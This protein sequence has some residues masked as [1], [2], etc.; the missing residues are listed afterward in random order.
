MA[1]IVLGLGTSH[2]P[3]LSLAPELWLEY[4]R[5]DQN[6]PELAYPPHGWVM[7][8]QAGLEYVSP[9]IRARFQGDA[10]FAA[11][12]AAFQRALDELARTLQSTEPDITV[13]ITDDQDEWFYEHNMPRFAVYWGESVPLIPRQPAMSQRAPE[14]AQAIVRGY[15]DVALDVPVASAFGRY[16]VEYLSEHD[17]D[18]AHLNY[19]CQPYGGRIARRY[20]RENGEADA[21]RETPS[22]EQGLPHGFSFVVKRLYDNKPRPILPIFQ[23]TCYP[24]NQ[25]SPRRSFAFG[26]AIGEAIRS[27]PE[28]ARVA[29]VASGGLSHFIVDEELDRRLL[30][31]LEEKDKQTLTSLPRERLYSATSE[32]LNWVAVGGAMQAT[33]LQF[34]LVDYVPVYRSPAGTGGG[35]AFGRWK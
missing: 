32:S 17:F 16:L 23:N 33:D 7:P 2:T 31:A 30:T 12:A 18:V 15:G 22:H 13:I 21:V 26:E 10:P 11:Q 19:V 4:A 20:P 34:E 24:P 1:E 3:L 9:E 5:G 25:P 6:N 35:W 14:V 28:S 27:W 8:Y 29:V